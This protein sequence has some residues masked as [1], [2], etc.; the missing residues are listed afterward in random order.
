MKS[1]YWNINKKSNWKVVVQV[2]FIVTQQVIYLQI[3]QF[4]HITVIAV[5]K[6]A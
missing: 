2:F 3:N 6:K 5:I 4:E 1:S